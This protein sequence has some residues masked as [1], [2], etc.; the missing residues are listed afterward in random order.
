MQLPEGAQPAFFWSAEL[1]LMNC[2]SSTEGD[3]WTHSTNEIDGI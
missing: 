1:Q 2:E 3:Q